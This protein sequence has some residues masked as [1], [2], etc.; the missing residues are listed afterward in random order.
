MNS[1]DILFETNRFNLSDEKPH[2]INPCCFGED[3]A[4]WLTGRLRARDIECTAPDQEDWGWY[5]DAE[6]N[7][8]PYLVCIA[9]NSSELTNDS[10]QGEWHVTVEKHR[11]FWQRLTRANKIDDEDMLALIIQRLLRQEPD[12]ANVHVER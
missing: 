1:C 7:G 9:G 11:T 5:F 4:N 8:Q 2:F 6:L 3:L 12:F 10:D